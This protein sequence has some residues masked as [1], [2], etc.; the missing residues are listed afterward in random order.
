MARATPRAAT[1]ATRTPGRS[2]AAIRKPGGASSRSRS[3]A[4]SSLQL[5][6]NCTRVPPGPVV[7]GP[8]P[9]GEASGRGGRQVLG[10]GGLERR[11]E[12]GTRF[13]LAQ[14]AADR[15]L[16]EQARDVGEHLDVGR[17]DA[18]GRDQQ[19]EEVR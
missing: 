15:L 18:L 14:A 5:A 4:E 11:E 2:S 3:K 12:G 17:A 1:R 8:R 9:T 19:D 7:T 13:G 10:F 6:R 16:L